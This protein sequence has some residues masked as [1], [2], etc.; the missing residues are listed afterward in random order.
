MYTQLVLNSKLENF[1]NLMNNFEDISIE[2]IFR[3]GNSEAD[4]LANLGADGHNI[5]VFNNG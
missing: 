1:I 4:G 5:L 3:E 2:H